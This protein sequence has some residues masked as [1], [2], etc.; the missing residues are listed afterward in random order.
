MVRDLVGRAPEAHR[1]PPQDK[2]D[3]AGRQEHP[4]D[5]ERQASQKV[6][7]SEERGE[8]NG[9]QENRGQQRDPNAA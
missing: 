3:Q 6:E 9:H 8:Q 5:H 7:R 1:G 4:P 2:R